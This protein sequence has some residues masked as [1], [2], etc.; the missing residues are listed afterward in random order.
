[1]TT[2]TSSE[3]VLEGE[4]EQQTVSIGADMGELAVPVATTE[5]LSVGELAEDPIQGEPSIPEEV[6]AI[7]TVDTPSEAASAVA[8]PDA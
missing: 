7:E 5:Q 1:M 2:S 6:A 4:V 3:V 8:A